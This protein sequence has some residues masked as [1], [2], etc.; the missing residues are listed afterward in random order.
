MTKVLEV[1]HFETL[2]TALYCTS[3]EFSV[4]M[5][6]PPICAIQDGS[7]Q[8]HVATKHL[9]DASV[10][11]PN[12]KFYIILFNLNLNSQMWLVATIPN[13]RG[14]VS[15]LFAI[16][17]K[18]YLKHDEQVYFSECVCT[19]THTVKMKYRVSRY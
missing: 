1:K 7:H 6:M 11:E 10:T 12:L 16:R 13:S 19:H 14:P 8:S 9:K 2:S 3:T 15:L 5:T 17:R 4:V 18:L